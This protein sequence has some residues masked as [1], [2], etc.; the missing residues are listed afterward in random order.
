MS[1]EKEHKFDGVWDARRVLYNAL[2]YADEKGSIK[3][4][5]GEVES[6]CNLE[7]QR[8]YAVLKAYGKIENDVLGGCEVGLRIG[9]EWGVWISKKRSQEKMKELY[10][11]LRLNMRNDFIM[12]GVDASIFLN[13]EYDILSFFRELFKYRKELYT[14]DMIWYGVLECSRPIGMVIETTNFLFHKH[15][16]PACDVIDRMLI[17]LMGDDFDK[18]FTEK[19]LLSY[20]YP[21][22]TDDELYRIKVDSRSG[23][24][25]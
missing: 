13:T 22:V 2:F 12:R 11:L 9:N 21:D 4:E 8:F 6:T 16:R 19:E 10:K 3:Y 17:L 15:I 5:T 24:Y 7:R 20:G 18:T 23:Y 14:L 25:D 1:K